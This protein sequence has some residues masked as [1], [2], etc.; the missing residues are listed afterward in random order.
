MEMKCIV[1]LDES[2]QFEYNCKTKH[3]ACC[4][5]CLSHLL[6]NN[7]AKI[8]ASQSHKCPYCLEVISEPCLFTSVEDQGDDILFLDFGLT[9]LKEDDDNKKDIHFAICKYALK[10]IVRIVQESDKLTEIELV[11][12]YMFFSGLKGLI[13][14]VSTETS[15]NKNL[16]SA[17]DVKNIISA[18]EILKLI[19]RENEEEEGP[20]T[21]RAKI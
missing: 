11:N 17:E 2:C 21:K 9:K 10:F 16:V 15:R 1:C 3:G 6:S 20:L 18:M 12:A 8:F 14:F 4:K 5:G 19:L 13:Q 7:I